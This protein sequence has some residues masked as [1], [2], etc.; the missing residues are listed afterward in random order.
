[1]ENNDKENAFIVNLSIDGTNIIDERVEIINPSQ[2]T[3]RELM[4]QIITVY[5]LERTTR[6][7]YPIQRLLG[8]D[9][10]DEEEPLIL[11]FTDVD[12]VE[13]TLADFD[14]QPDDYL[15]LIMVPL[16]GCLPATSMFPMKEEDDRQ[17]KGR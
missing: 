11:E 15:H 1:M 5:G 17:P 14:V 6:D 4:D 8:I 10:N 9:L 12:G 13:L 7:G 3:I 2:F 16:Y